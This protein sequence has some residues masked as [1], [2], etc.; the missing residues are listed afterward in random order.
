[1]P[2]VLQMTQIAQNLAEVRRR[3]AAAAYKAGR[4]PAQV[5]LVAV[6]KTVPVELH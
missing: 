3:I 4:D 5:R 6:S 2:P 1:M